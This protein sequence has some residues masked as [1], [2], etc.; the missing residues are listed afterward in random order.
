MANQGGFVV[1]NNRGRHDAAS[2]LRI[3]LN[4]NLRHPQSPLL[5][6]TRAVCR[7][8]QSLGQDRNFGGFRTHADAQAFFIAAG[9]P[10]G[11]IEKF[12]S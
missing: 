12:S 2:R 6:Q 11:F 4:R 8:V 5:D 9:G 3:A 1:A 10:G 7:S